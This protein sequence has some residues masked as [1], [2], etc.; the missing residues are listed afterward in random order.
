[1]PT[2]MNNLNFEGQN[3][4]AGFDVHLKDWKVTILSEEMMLKSFTM[5]PNPEVFKGAVTFGGCALG[6]VM[7]C[8]LLRTKNCFLSGVCHSII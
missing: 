6:R 1:M 2:Q 3:I 4:Y 8:A 7:G 5:P